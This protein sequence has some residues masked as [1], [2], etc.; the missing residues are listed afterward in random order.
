MTYAGTVKNGVIVLDAGSALPEGARVKV[1]SDLPSSV[2]DRLMAHAGIIDDLPSD[3][4]EKHDE[5]IHGQLTAEQWSREWRAWAESHPELDHIADD[6]RES[7][8]AGRGE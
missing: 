3:M 8:Y 7:I 5:Y 4:A 6:S 1:Q 2:G